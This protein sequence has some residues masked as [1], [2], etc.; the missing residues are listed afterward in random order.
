MNDEVLYSVRGITKEYRQNRVVISVLRGID[1]DVRAGEI[2]SIVGSSGVGKSTLLN[3]L[4]LLDTPTAGSLRY[5]SRRT[6]GP[7]DLLSMG[8]KGRA[9]IRNE[10]FGFVFQF[11]HL[12]PDLS[13]LENTLLPAMIRHGRLAY[14]AQRTELT[15]RAEE[16]LDR[17]G[18]LARKDFSPT[19]LSGGERQ[20]AAIARALLNEPQ[21]VFCDEPTGNLDTVTGEKIHQL[22]VELQRTLRVTFILVTHDERLAS[23]AD[24]RLV[25]RDGVFIQPTPV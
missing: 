6:S 1:L 18:I 5:H 7:V 9:R 25:M 11:Y 20:R 22:M 13:V 14:R 19:Q 24:R 10:E 23:L 12:L 21:L 4:G 2:L 17:V 8:R 16:L 15:R 3:L